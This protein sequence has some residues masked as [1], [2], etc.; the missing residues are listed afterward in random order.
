M[1]DTLHACTSNIK[2]HIYACIAMNLLLLHK[3]T[4]YKSCMQIISICDINIY[5]NTGTKI[6][7]MLCDYGRRVIWQTYFLPTLPPLR[8]KDTAAGTVKYNIFLLLHKILYW[9]IL[10]R[11]IFGNFP[12]LP[13]LN[14]PFSFTMHMLNDTYPPIHQN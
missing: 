10:K 13:K 9:V 4:K 7:S 1:V 3:N 8:R 11:F 14:L 6:I 2:I 5:L 12:I